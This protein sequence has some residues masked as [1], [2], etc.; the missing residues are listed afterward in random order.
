MNSERDPYTKP[1]DFQQSP[2]ADEIRPDMPP[3]APEDS[4]PEPSDMVTGDSNNRV[5]AIVETPSM[6]K[7]GL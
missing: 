1:G 5:P 4:A 3:T 2:T 6:W 7:A